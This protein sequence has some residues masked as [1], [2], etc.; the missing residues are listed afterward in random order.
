MA[1]RRG[2]RVLGDAVDGVIARRGADIRRILVEYGV[3]LV[4]REGGR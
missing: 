3:P 2:D 1:V 4:D